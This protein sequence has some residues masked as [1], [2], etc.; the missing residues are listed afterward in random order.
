MSELSSDSSDGITF[1]ERTTNANFQERLLQAKS[2]TAFDPLN[3]DTRF[4]DFYDSD[5]TEALKSQLERLTQKVYHMESRVI[6]RE[7]KLTARREKRRV[8]AGLTN[9]TTEERAA[10]TEKEEKEHEIAKK[11]KEDLREKLLKKEIKEINRDENDEED[12]EEEQEQEELETQPEDKKPDWSVVY[13]YMLLLENES[14]NDEMIFG[15]DF[16][17]PN[18]ELRQKALENEEIKRQT[19]YSGITILKS[20]QVL[21]GY[22]E[23]ETGDIRHCELSGTSY[24]LTFQVKFDVLEPSMIMPK[25]DFEVNI[26]MQLAVGSTLQKIKNECNIFGFFQLLVHYAKLE[27]GRKDIFD[28]LIKNYKDTPVNVVLL[29]Q[30]KLQFEGSIGCGISL[31]LSWKI[32]ETNI[33]R[34]KLDANVKN[35]VLPD[36]TMEAVALPGVISKDTNGSLDKINSAFIHMIKQK[37]V[38]E[39][40]KY[41]VDN[42]LLKKYN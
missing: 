1:D 31:L 17:N 40:T 39:G 27:N 34:E 25:L 30:T 16:L 9:M 36:L 8:E 10:F 26:E 20:S 35:D 7:E 3:N 24:D 28:Q 33:D 14:M 18:A 41:I 2:S 29:S 13:E 15:T 37:G 32:I 12:E 42:I 11:K 21:E 19:E 4:I 38:Y 5:D 22:K 6:E 23:T